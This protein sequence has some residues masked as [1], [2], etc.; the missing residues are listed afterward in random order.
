MAPAGPPRWAVCDFLI[1]AL[2]RTTWSHPCLQPPP[3]RMRWTSVRVT[4]SCL[5]CLCS[6]PT[7]G[8]WYVVASHGC[9]C[10]CACGCM[11]RGKHCGSAPNALRCLM[12]SHARAGVALCLVC[13]CVCPI[14][15]L[16]A[17]QAYT[18]VLNGAFHL[19]APISGS[20]SLELA[21]LCA[22]AVGLASP[23]TLT[24]SCWSPS[25]SHWC[26]ALPCFLCWTSG[27]KLVLPGAGMD[28]QSVC[29]LL[30]N[31]KV[32][33]AAGVPTVWS[34]LLHYLQTSKK[35]LPELKVRSVCAS[36]G[37]ARGW[38]WEVGGGMRCVGMWQHCGCGRVGVWACGRVGVW[39]V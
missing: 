36:G 5:L 12:D 31:E 25:R 16:C 9:G 23:P 26:L 20:V 18:G 24:R 4:P 8:V 28:G 11:W 10:S 21:R 37:V 14:G 39:A 1:P 2:T 30:S 27:S 15:S 7:A 6:T 38:T 34:M 3:C 13:A 35:T 17:A 29:E 33:F 22:A 19:G 32:N